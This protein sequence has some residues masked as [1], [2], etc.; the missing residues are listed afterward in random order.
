MNAVSGEE[1]LGHKPEQLSIRREARRVKNA[2]VI[3]NRQAERDHHAFG[4]GQNF[5][6]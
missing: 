4:G 5:L 2:I 6:Q 1:L 3:H